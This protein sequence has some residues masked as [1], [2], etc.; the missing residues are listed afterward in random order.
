[1]AAAMMRCLS[2]ALVLG[3]MIAP[4][5]AHVVLEKREAVV[6]S[7][8]KAVFQVGHGCD[9]SP[10]TAIEVQ[11][12]DGVIAAKPMQKPGWTIATTKGPYAQAHAHHGH[13]VAEGVRS[14]TWTGRLPDEF[15]EEFVMSVMITDTLAPGTALYFP[16]IQTCE[17]GA[18]RWVDRPEP[19]QPASR[20]PAPSLQLLPKR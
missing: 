9:G 18:S 8:Y 10:T 11:I 3:A 13:A 2:L 14:V 17:S 15:Y 20:T 1:M 7:Y 4:A 6:G 12:P 5:S 16:V 19:N